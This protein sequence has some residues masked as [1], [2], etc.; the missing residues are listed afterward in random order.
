MARHHYTIDIVIAIYVMPLIWY[1][2]SS[3]VP[4]DINP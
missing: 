1:W 2:H 3:Y 4:K